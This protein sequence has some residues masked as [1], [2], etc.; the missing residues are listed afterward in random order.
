MGLELEG[1]GVPE[2]SMTGRLRSRIR[3][4]G[5]VDNGL[6]VL[7]PWARYDERGAILRAADI[8][9]VAAKNLAENRLA[10]RTRMLDHFWAG[11]PTLATSGDVLADLVTET[12]AGI[13]VPPEDFPALR[14]GLRTLLGDAELRQHCSAAAHRLADRYRWT[15]A[16]APIVRVINDPAP[17]RAARR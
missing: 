3:D 4:L 12:G 11:L 13:V 17:Y 2:M 16:V 7:G 5:L 14:N 9:V 15:D 1:R 10:F 8:G 6:V